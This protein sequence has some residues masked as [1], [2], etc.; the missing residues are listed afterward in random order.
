MTGEKREHIGTLSHVDSLREIYFIKE[1]DEFY[2]F[3]KKLNDKD[4]KVN[5]PINRLCDG[6]NINFSLAYFSFCKNLSH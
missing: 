1:R 6:Q 5:L 4:E 2:N 3:C